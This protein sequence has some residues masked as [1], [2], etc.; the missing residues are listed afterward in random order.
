MYKYLYELIADYVYNRSAK[1][2]GIASLEYWPKG[3][4]FPGDFKRN[5][6]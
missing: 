5:I 2:P 1:I 6:L 3:T 4:V